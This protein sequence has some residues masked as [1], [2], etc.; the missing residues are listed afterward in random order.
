MMSPVLR[1]RPPRA[2]DFV[3]VPDSL[4][5][6]P[7]IGGLPERVF[8]RSAEPF[9]G[10]GAL[11]PHQRRGVTAGFA[12]RRG[13]DVDVEGE[14]TIELARSL[15]VRQPIVGERFPSRERRDAG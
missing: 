11:R 12:A 10:V 3:R 4:L 8:E 13:L 14:L 15:P 5:D 9:P 7:P 2:D 1:L 6:T